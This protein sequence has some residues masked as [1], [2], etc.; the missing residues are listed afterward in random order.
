MSLPRTPLTSDEELLGA[1]HAVLQS[2]MQRRAADRAHAAR[3]S[4]RL[5]DARDGAPRRRAVRLTLIQTHKIR[6][7]PVI[8]VGGDYWQ[9]LLDWVSQRMLRFGSVSR[10][11]V[12]LLQ[13]AE[14]AGAGAFGRGG[15]RP[16]PGALRLRRPRR[17]AEALLALRQFA[18]QG[19]YRTSQWVTKFCEML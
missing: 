1:E 12:A 18:V 17:P 3:A 5:R 13:L 7:F 9:G 16:P 11:D 14:G 15:G 6:H 19:K 8:L 10:E 4:A 2:R